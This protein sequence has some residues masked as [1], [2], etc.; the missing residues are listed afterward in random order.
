MF[1]NGTPSFSPV[2]PVDAHLACRDID[3][4]LEHK[5]RLRPSGAAIGVDW[6]GVSEDHLDL[7]VDGWGGIDAGKQWAVKVGRDVGPE[8]R[9]VA[10]KIGDG[11]YPQPEKLAVGVERELRLGDVITAVSVRDKS[12][13]ALAHPLDRPPDLAASPGHNGLF[14][15]VELLHAEAAADI[16][17]YHPQLLLRDVEH[18]QAHKQPH[19][20]RKLA[21]RPKRV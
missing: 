9:D 12:F 17:C 10:A 4:S 21:C 14:G 19:H 6:H 2:N 8:R 15:V 11:L 16:G 18:E 1:S 7:A 13:A 5:G 20:V 3:Q